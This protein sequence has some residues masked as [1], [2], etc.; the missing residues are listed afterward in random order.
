MTVEIVPDGNCNNDLNSLV[1][2]IP[3]NLK[4]SFI[5]YIYQSHFYSSL[6]E[7]IKLFQV[8]DFVM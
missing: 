7:A 8:L 3:Y 5:L 2:C 6:Q 1:V 4:F